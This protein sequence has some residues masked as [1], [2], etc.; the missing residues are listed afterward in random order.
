MDSVMVVVNSIAGLV[1]NNASFSSILLVLIGFILPAVIGMILPRRKTIGYG[2]FIYKS[3]GIFLAQKRLNTSPTHPL[4]NILNVLRTTFIDM[5][6][7]VYI[8][9]RTDLSKEDVDKKIE[10][11]IAL[12]IEKPST[13]KP[14]E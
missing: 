2:R 11:Y 9:S 8:E 13:E 5:S 7:G 12:T 4:L 3:L 14:K 1:K 6:Y 10:E